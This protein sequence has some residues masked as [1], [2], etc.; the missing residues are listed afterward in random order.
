MVR[1]LRQRGFGNSLTQLQKK[2]I[3]QHKQQWLQSTAHY[4]TD[5]Q[6]LVEASKRQLVLAP[7]FDEPSSLP[8]LSKACWLLT[9]YCSDV[10]SPLEKVK[11]YITST[12]GRVLKIDSTKKAKYYKQ[13]NY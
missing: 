10:L 2:L 5:G 8:T 11:A 1:L 6:T 9:V 12:F 3:E 4:L 7:K 13:V